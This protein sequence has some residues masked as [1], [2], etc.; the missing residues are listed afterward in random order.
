MSD[1]REHRRGTVDII[2]RNN[3]KGIEGVNPLPTDEGIR[4]LLTDDTPCPLIDAA[5]VFAQEIPNPTVGPIDSPKRKFL[6]LDDR[7]EY[8]LDELEQAFAA[9]GGNK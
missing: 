3:D 4:Q 2:F 6:T 7:K 9:F 1:L 8:S 5:A